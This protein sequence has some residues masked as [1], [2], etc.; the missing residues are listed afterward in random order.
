MPRGKD[1]PRTA[2]VLPGG[3]ARGAFQVGVLKA[4]AEILPRDSSNPFQI[5]SGTSAG[6]VN[7]VVLASRAHSFRTAVAELER[8]WG[9]FRCNHVYRTD[10]LTMLKSS[11][12]WMIAL[13]FGGWL[14]GMPKSLLDNSPLRDLLGRNV[15][16]PRIRD[17]IEDG[18]LAAAAVTAAGYASARSTT[19]FEAAPQ[20]TG[21]KRTRRV[22]KNTELNLDHLMASIAVPMV[23][24]PVRIGNEY[25]GDGAMR[26]ATPLSPVVRLGADRILVIGMR[27]ETGGVEPKTAGDPPS[28]GQ[29]AGYML[30]TLFMDGLYSDLERVTRVNDLLDSMPDA[31]P[32]A[33]SRRYRSIDT[34]LIVPSED[35][36]SIAEKHRAELPFAIRA[37]LRGVGGENKLLS[38]LMFERAYTRELMKLGYR[39]AIKVRD[40]LHAFVTGG[41]VPRLFAPNWIKRDLSGFGSP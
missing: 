15:H 40:Q 27:D 16:F 26:Q 28:F 13:A 17:A 18:H 24:P 12:H 20:Q 39:D 21:W 1:Q 22:G 36:Q 23:F 7:S 31:K 37:L 6:A 8:V 2:L 25:F 19:F 38:F 29:I 5:I 35:L 4:I 41:D 14:V 34:M 32:V 11:L 33:E 10:H 3:G 9:H 30:D